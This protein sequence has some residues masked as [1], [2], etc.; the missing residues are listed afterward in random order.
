MIQVGVVSRSFRE[1]AFADVAK[2]MR[3]LGF[4][5]TEL[6]FTFKECNVWAYNGSTDMNPLTDKLAAEIVNTFRDN[7]IYIASLGAFSSM[8]EPDEEKQAQ[9][10]RTYERYFQIAAANGIPAVATEA[11]FIPGRR[12]IVF[13]SYEKDF[14]YFKSNLMKVLEMAEKYGVDLALE[15]CVLD[16]T[17][18]AKRARDLILQSG[19][20]RLKVL[21]DPANL[22]ANSDEEDMFKYLTP[23]ISYFHGKDRKVNDASGRV[24]GDGE[25]DWPLFLKFYHEH[26]EGVPF[27]LEYVNPDNCAEIRDRVLAFDQLV[28]R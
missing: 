8:F 23:Y 12:G 20:E 24:V 7:G 26:C 18:S 25:I 17:P 1:W 22:I 21:L 27:I 5:S 10:L 9:N 4:V 13:D 6:C 2:K 3:E 28:M 11:G 19:S 16:L 14:D 15:N